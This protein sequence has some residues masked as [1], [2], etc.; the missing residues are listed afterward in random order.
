MSIISNKIM[1][2]LIKKYLPEL[3]HISLL[4][5]TMPLSTVYQSRTSSSFHFACSYTKVIPD[6]E[7]GNL[8]K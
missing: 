2:W 7:Y 8:Q 3:L 5:V 1:Q 4:F 6:A